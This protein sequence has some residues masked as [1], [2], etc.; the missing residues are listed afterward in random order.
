[1]RSRQNSS[2][3][4]AMKKTSKT[5]A[6]PSAG[7]AS[8]K[9]I[10][11]KAELVKP[12]KSSP[13]SKKGKD[14]AS[15]KLVGK[16]VANEMMDK[17]C[18]RY[19][20]ADCELDF[21]SDFQLLTSVILSAQTTDVAVNKCTPG[22]FKRFPDAKA[23]AEA[24]IEDIK[25]LIK[26]TGFFNAKANNIQKCAQALVSKFGGKVPG[27]LEELTTL[28]GVGRKTANVVLGVAFDVPGW[29]VD[30]HVQRLT[31]RLGFTKETDP[32]KIELDL[33]K[34]FPEKDWTKYSITLI[35]HG[36]RLC[37]ARNPDCANCPINNLC[38]SSQV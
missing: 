33:Q 38:P 30:T 11:P 32:Y 8:T 28:P 3:R 29:T 19:P 13:S 22:L 1:M 36:R 16:E 35:W 12:K 14:A 23:L 7:K 20:D 26:Q 10:K 27:T 6:K 4:I 24:D 5:N 17:L 37:Y 18:K 21:E 15:V 34:L 31:A 25:V 2:S 9:P